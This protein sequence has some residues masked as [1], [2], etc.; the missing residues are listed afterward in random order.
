MC[1]VKTCNCWSLLADCVLPSWLVC[2]GKASSDNTGPAWSMHAF[3]GIPVLIFA[4]LSIEPRNPRRLSRIFLPV[5][6]NNSKA[7]QQKQF[8]CEILYETNIF[9]LQPVQPY[10]SQVPCNYSAC[11]KPWK[12][13]VLS[14]FGPRAWQNLHVSGKDEVSLNMLSPEKDILG[15]PVEREDTAEWL[16]VLQIMSFYVMNYSELA[17]WAA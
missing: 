14:Q 2:V 8:M 13:W 17:L 4:V 9:H 12:D 6:F 7:S 15:C 11:D 5:C 10:W 16:R 1:T 3:L